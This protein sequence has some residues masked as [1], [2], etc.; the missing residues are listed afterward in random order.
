MT[1][2]TVY[3]YFTKRYGFWKRRGVA[4]PE[5]VFGF[6]N[7]LKGTLGKESLPEFLS[8]VYNGH[9]NEPLIGVFLRT[10]PLLF[11][12]DPDFIKNILIRDF[13]KFMN[14]GFLKSEPVSKGK[15]SILLRPP[16]F[17]QVQHKTALRKSYM[18]RLEGNSEF[19]QFI[20]I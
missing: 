11:V 2:I 16:N 18:K 14:R 4:G 13:P 5:P 1:L 10:M 12:K 9:K 19:H 7:F 15:T 6:G 8:R 20:F 3:C 17:N